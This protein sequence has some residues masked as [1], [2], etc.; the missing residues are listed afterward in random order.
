MPF[1]NT[2]GTQKQLPEYFK[3]ANVLA[4]V[5]AILTVVV[6]FILTTFME[7]N[8]EL[9]LSID[10]YISLVDKNKLS[11]S[12]I[13]VYFDTLLVDDL[14][15]ANCS[16]TNSGS[17]AITKEDIIDNIKI[18]LSQETKLLKYE[19]QSYPNTIKSNDAIDGNTI[20]LTPDLLNPN[21]KISLTIYYTVDKIGVLPSTQSRI[22]DGQIITNNQLNVSNKKSKF[23]IPLSTSLENIL[24]WITLVFSML[25]IIIL[26]YMFFSDNNLGKMPAIMIM[27]PYI[28]IVLYLLANEWKWG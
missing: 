24:L 17:L 26:T 27:L 12:G 5:L 16:L 20:L 21:E 28:L 7:K 11:K 25:F 18:F 8:K 1:S 23:I 13:K 6:P 9:T 3:Y 14:Y 10:S 4:V 2:Q 19:I 22:I 15:K